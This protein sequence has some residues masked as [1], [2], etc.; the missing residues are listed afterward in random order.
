ME[1][2]TVIEELAHNGA[3]LEESEVSEN[4]VIEENQEVSQKTVSMGDILPTT[5]SLEGVQTLTV[6]DVTLAVNNALEES[7]ITVSGGSSIWEK[8]LVEYTVTESLLLILVL[9][10][11]GLVIEKIIGGV[12]NCTRLFKK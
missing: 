4:E 3:N 5:Y 2:S 7:V 11:I 1:E 9:C 6:E 12:L 10:A 8:P